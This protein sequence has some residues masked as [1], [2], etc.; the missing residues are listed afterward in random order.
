MRW[1]ASW[2]QTEIASSV[3]A[4]RSWFDAPNRVQNFDPRAA[5]REASRNRPAA[6]P[7]AGCRRRAAGAASPAD[8]LLHD[9]A[10]EPHADVEGVEDEGREGHRAEGDRER[11][12]L[13]PDDQGQELADAVA[14]DGARRQ[15]LEAASARRSS[16]SP[17]R[18]AP[19][20]PRPAWRRSRSGACGTPARP[21]SSVVPEHTR[22]WNPEQAPQ[23]MVTKRKG[24]SEPVM[25]PASQVGKP[26]AGSRSRRRRCRRSPTASAV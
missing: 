22:P 13:A 9:V 17:A 20:S 24:K 2:S 8:Q 15:A 3:S 11:Q 14:V 23:A 10:P 12:A 4:A 7:S 16:P 5:R 21:A 18:S 25:P 6:P 26:A 19:R 1:R